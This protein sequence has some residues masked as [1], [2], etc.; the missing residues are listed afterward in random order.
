MICSDCPTIG[1][2]PGAPGIYTYVASAANQL[3][4]A[5]TDTVVVT[6]V[7]PCQVDEIEAANAF[8]PNGDGFNDRFEIRNSGVSTIGLVQ[9]FNRWGEMVFETNDIS[10]QWDGTFRQE[11]VNPGVYMYLFRG[12]CESGQT[13]IVSGN[14]TVIR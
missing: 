9:V 4:C 10:D 5:E 8:T 1:E 12:V 6:V 14:V 2:S 3:G 11:P 13:F 7:D